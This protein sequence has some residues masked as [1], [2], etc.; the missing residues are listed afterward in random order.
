MTLY[1]IRRSQCH[2]RNSLRPLA[3]LWFGLSLLTLS[4]LAEDQP[5]DDPLP[6]LVEVLS[7]NDDPQFQ[8]DILK[9]M[10]EALKGRRQ[11]PMPKGWED[12]EKKL[13][14]SN[15]SE[16]RE[17]V[18]AL[19]LTF[20]SPQAMAALL[21]KLRDRSAP[22]AA[23]RSALESLLQVKDPGLATTL[24][25]LLSDPPLRGA[26]LRGL[27]AFDHPKTPEKIFG[28]YGRL[29]LEEKRDAL[30]TLAS[31]SSFARSLLAAVERAQI[32][33]KDL[34]AD[35]IRQLRAFKDPQ[36]EAQ[37]AKVWG[38]A[39]ESSAD[40][41]KEIERYKNIVLAAGAPPDPA[42]G[43]VL[44][45]KSCQ[46]CHTLFDA[47]GQVGPNLTGSNRADLDYILQNIV[48]PNAVIPNDYRAWT[49]ETKDDRV[50]TGILKQQDPNAVTIAT[51][52]ETLTIPRNEIQSLHQNELSM[53]P[54]GLLEQFSPAEVRDLIV[55][56]KQAAPLR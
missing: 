7:Q 51:Q 21:E 4:I 5:A 53:M 32:P 8:L 45:E 19:S 49:L 50:I 28:I 2:L 29:T 37:I 44:F 15:N 40:K 16:I 24:Q 26:V 34:T 42:L 52:T 3:F 43:R 56:L 46:Q 41:Q 20:G 6:A 22:M 39:R 18:L 55:Y 54:E 10:N 36:I 31:R 48:D 14:R 27:A 13:S 12:L 33:A 1:P 30:S 23:R 17:A 38:V 35:L 47:G 9:G 11:V 25:D